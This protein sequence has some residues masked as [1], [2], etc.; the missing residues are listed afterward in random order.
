MDG[1]FEQQQVDPSL[2]FRGSR[3]QRIITITKS[4]NKKIGDIEYIINEG[5]Y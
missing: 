4:K 1:K 2:K 3:N 5:K